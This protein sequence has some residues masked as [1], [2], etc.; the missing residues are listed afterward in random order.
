MPDS[1][2]MK[3]I[4]DLGSRIMKVDHAGEHGAVNIYTGQRVIPE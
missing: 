1:L 2:P 3:R 4:P